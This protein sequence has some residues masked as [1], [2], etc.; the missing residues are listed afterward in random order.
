M[1]F[2]HKVFACFVFER[3]VLFWLL[4]VVRARDVFGIGFVWM[5][6]TLIKSNYLDFTEKLSKYRFCRPSD[7]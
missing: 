2:F 4:A 7:S 1:D 3:S 5:P 6:L